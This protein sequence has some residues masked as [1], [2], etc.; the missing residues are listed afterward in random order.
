MKK[1][2]VLLALISILAL[3]LLGCN[4]SPSS[5][6]IKEAF[7]ESVCKNYIYVIVED[8]G[9]ELTRE[10]FGADIVKD[11]IKISDYDDVSKK[12]ELQLT[13]N[14]PFSLLKAIGKIEKLSQVREVRL[15]YVMTNFMAPNDPSFANGNQWG[16]TDIEVE[17]VWD[18]TIGSALINVGIVDSGIYNHSDIDGNI[19]V[20]YDFQND[21]YI[22]NDDVVGHGTFVTGIVGAEGNNTEGISGINWCVSLISLQTSLANIGSPIDNVTD[23]VIHAQGTY[24]TENPIRIINISLGNYQNSKDMQALVE[25]MK[26]YTGLIICAAGNDGRNTDSTHCY[27][28]YYGSNLLDDPIDHMIV[29]GAIDG[30]DARSVWNNGK[31]SNYGANTVD[32]YAPGSNIYSTYLN[33]GY[34]TDGGTSYAAPY[35]TGVAALLWSV[36][37]NLTALQIKDCILNGADEIEIEVEPGFLGFGRETQIVKKLN[38]WGAFKYLM[39][40]YYP[41]LEADIGYSDIEFTDYIDADGAYFTDHTSMVKFNV[42]VDGSYTFTVSADEEIETVF[43]NSDFE[44]INVTQTSADEDTCKQFTYVLSEGTYYLKA[45]YSSE[46]SAGEITFSVDCPPHTH[47]YTEWK[48]YSKEKHIESCECGHIGTY[49]TVHVAAAGSI[50]NF[51][52]LCMYCGAVLN[53]IDDG[54]IG[55]MNINKYSINGSYILPNGIIVLVDED[56]EAY[57]SG[58]LVF[59]DKDDLPVVQ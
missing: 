42:L 2:L 1:L 5:I 40:N 21:N 34:L 13:T 23:A 57:E 20:G 52:G 55:I 47:E 45:N 51:K 56:I 15:V 7:Q 12:Y 33:N 18:F 29:V 25:S 27:P 59:Y 30:N 43:Y 46:L 50:G 38:A 36:D 35:V 28:G 9:E 39:N 32:I 49:T 54:H 58:T 41:S 11:I 3:V 53:F 48:Y 8:S 37:P 31:S 22:T 4:I 17:K 16:L 10:Y 19:G 14:D 26:E 44:E 24:D 6:S